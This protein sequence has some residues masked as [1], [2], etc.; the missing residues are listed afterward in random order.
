MITSPQYF[1]Y[2]T[3]ID[4][5]FENGLKVFDSRELLNEWLEKEGSKMKLKY[6]LVVAGYKL[7][8]R[9]QK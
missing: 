9:R 8:E 2:Y 7:D 6:V 3:A 1:L 5:S 4:N